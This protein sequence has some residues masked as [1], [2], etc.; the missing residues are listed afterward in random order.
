MISWTARDRRVREGLET[1]RSVLPHRLTAQ[2]PPVPPSCRP[3]TE[4]HP[5]PWCVALV[6]LKVAILRLPRRRIK[7][8]SNMVGLITNTEQAKG[9]SPS[10]SR[11]G[12]R[13]GWDSRGISSTPTWPSMRL[14]DHSGPRYFP[15]G[16][17]RQFPNIRR[18]DYMHT[19]R[20]RGQ[21][22]PTSSL[23]RSNLPF[24]T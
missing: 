22:K 1:R 14:G 5:A 18:F 16:D 13:I 6:E 9:F 17:A 19:D 23:H 7:L 15:H 3:L 2:I 21:G 20:R 8:D 12:P 10:S 11:D 4:L 24:E